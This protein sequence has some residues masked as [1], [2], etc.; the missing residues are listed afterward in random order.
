MIAKT[1][2]VL[3]KNQSGV[4]FFDI[5]DIYSN[6]SRKASEIKSTFGTLQIPVGAV[7]NKTRFQCYRVAH[8]DANVEEASIVDPEIVRPSKV[9]NVTKF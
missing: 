8:I 4:F 2:F 7:E 5:M 3:S 6:G 9:F 1:E